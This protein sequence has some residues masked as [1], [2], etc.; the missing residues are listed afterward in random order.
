MAL[1]V[2]TI[3]D[4][5][6]SEVEVSVQCEPPINT[7]NPETVLTGAQQTALAMLEVTQSSI[8]KDRGLIELIN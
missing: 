1:I 5:V 7:K 3:A 2:I 4:S 6:D 8:K